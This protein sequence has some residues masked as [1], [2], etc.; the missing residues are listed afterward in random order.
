MRER[1]CL[2]LAAVFL[3]LAI[4]GEVWRSHQPIPKPPARASMP[5][6]GDIWIG[7]PAWTITDKDW[8]GI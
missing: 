4:A 2:S 7:T 5:D 3:L 6:M 1:I 8:R